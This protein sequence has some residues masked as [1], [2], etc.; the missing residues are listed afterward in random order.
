MYTIHASATFLP[1]VDAKY[2]TLCGI[3]YLKA[4]IWQSHLLTG[5]YHTLPVC[6]YEV[7]RGLSNREA[8]VIYKNI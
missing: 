8:E 2:Y 6:R 3:A 5:I 7:S 4:Y 1:S